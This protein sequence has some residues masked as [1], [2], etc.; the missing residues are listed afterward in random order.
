MFQTTNT[1]CRYVTE[2]IFINVTGA[3]L[4]LNQALFSEKEIR[5]QDYNTHFAENV[6]RL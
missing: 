5:Q 3:L 2:F 4:Q 1:D 6:L